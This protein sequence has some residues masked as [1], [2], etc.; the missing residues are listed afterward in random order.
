MQREPDL[1][2]VSIFTF[3]CP[4]Q[5]YGLFPNVHFSVHTRFT[6]GFHMHILVF[7]PDLPLI[8]MFIQFLDQIYRWFPCV[9]FSVY[10][11]FTTAFNMLIS[12]F[13]VCW[14][15]FHFLHQWYAR[16]KWWHFLITQTYR[17]FPYEAQ[18]EFRHKWKVVNGTRHLSTG[19]N[20]RRF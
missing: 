8:S 11:R 9:Q 5:I 16:I 15:E 12:V 13:R 19:K 14:T 3:Q 17:W 7:R 6:A 10:T 2:L 1:P 20:I 4:D 18:E